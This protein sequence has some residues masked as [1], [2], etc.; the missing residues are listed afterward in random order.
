MRKP[1]ATVGRSP[2]D[3]LRKDLLAIPGMPSIFAEERAALWAG[4]F[5]RN[6]RRG[7]VDLSQ[8]GPADLTG[9]LQ[10]S[11]EAAMT[12]LRC[13]SHFARRSSPL[14]AALAVKLTE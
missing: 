12:L 8:A 7:D 14:V 4:R 10:A 9:I 3:E 5:I 11:G 13:P 1:V 6:F 2:L